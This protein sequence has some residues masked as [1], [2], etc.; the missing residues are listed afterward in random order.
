[1]AYSPAREK[2]KSAKENIQVYFRLRPQ[3]EAEISNNDQKIWEIQDN[4][5]RINTQVYEEAS[6]KNFVLFSNK[7]YSYN[8]CF[9][10]EVENSQIYSEA[11]KPIVMSSL[12]GINGTVFMYGQTGSGKTHTMLGDYSKEIREANSLGK[13]SGSNKMRMRS[14][15]RNKNNGL[16][17]NSSLGS[18]SNHSNL[19]HTHRQNPVF[20]KTASHGV[21]LPPKAST[22][23]DTQE[24]GQ[25]VQSF[26]EYI[27]N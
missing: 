15:S 22:F 19:P 27:R 6:N 21:G 16:N 17:R 26:E 25:N 20:M 1:M 7:Q 24:G 11:I 2:S 10:E 18:L 3:S 14:G 4:S 5:V 8:S 23:R 9:N 13:R 12:D